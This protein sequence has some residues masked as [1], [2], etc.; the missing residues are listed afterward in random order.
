MDNTLKSIADEVTLILTKF[1]ENDEWRVDPDFIY[2]KIAQARE[3]AI[4][5]KF[6]G[7]QGGEFKGLVDQTWMQDLGM[8]DFHRVNFADDITLTSCDCDIYKAFLPQIISLSDGDGYQELGITVISSCGKNKF[9]P[10]P[11]SQWKSIP[12]GHERGMFGY[13]AR[14]NN[15][16]YTSKQGRKRIYGLLQNPED[17]KLIQSEPI[18]SGSIVLGTIYRVKFGPVI[19]DGQT[20]VKDSVFT[21]SAITTFTG[22]GTVYLNSQVIAYRELD[23]YPVNGDMARQ[24]VL[25]I[26]VKEFG[27]EKQAIADIKNDSRDDATKSQ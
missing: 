23:K 14:I 24:I 9:Y 27:I 15:A 20:Y 22:T 5:D 19:Y 26:C 18:A 21:G 25:D 17:G 6:T 3:G 10:Y 13:F 4:I 11:L 12:E 16:M 2:K 1:S 7:K 8:V